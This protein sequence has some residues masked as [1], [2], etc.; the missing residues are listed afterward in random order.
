MDTS[1]G[2]T[3]TILVIEPSSARITTSGLEYP[4]GDEEVN[5]SSTRGVSNV[6]LGDRIAVTVNGGVALVL[7][8][9]AD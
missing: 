1:P 8:E 6:A 3:V 9:W 4:L 7:R 5:Q 2:Q